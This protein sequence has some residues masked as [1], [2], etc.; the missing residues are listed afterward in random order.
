MHVRRSFAASL[1]VAVIASA[2]ASTGDDASTTTRPQNKP[3][4]APATS[5]TLGPLEDLGHG[6][7]KDSIK[8]G[9]VYID[10]STIAD[11]VDFQ[12]GD[13]EKIAQAFVDDVNANGGVLGR[14]LVPVYKKYIPIPGTNVFSTTV[15]TELTDDE[16]VFAVLGV[17]YDATGRAQ[18]CLS[19]DHQTIHIGHEMSEEWLNASK[20]LMLTPDSTKEAKIRVL[21]A[22]LKREATLQNRK[23]AVTLTDQDGVKLVERSVNPALK[24]LGIPLGTAG[25]LAIA[26]TDTAEAQSQLQTYLSTWEAEG[27]DTIV[28]VSEL[29][30]AKQF[31]EVIRAKFPNVQLIAAVSTGVG[32]EAKDEIIAKRSPNPYEGILTVE[33]VTELTRYASPK[34][35]ACIK[36]YEEATKSKVN[37]PD[38]PKIVKG[39]RDES[40][41]AIQDFCGEIAMFVTIAERVGRTL[42]NENWMKTVDSFG[43][44]EIV[45]TDIASLGANKY[46]ADDAQSLVAWD[47]SLNGGK[48]GWKHLTKVEDTFELSK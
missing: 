5:T 42:T 39:D 47:S 46:Y 34:T 22:L 2:C 10:Y 19:K 38:N 30:S 27:V 48:G 26:G 8:I 4:A 1:V 40:Y 29:V 18:L 3:T 14:K 35:Q 44:I 31:T 24:S 37:G 21:F 17:V 13:Q 33:G 25:V 6:V 41:V 45:P 11:F 28:L 16:D 36:I 43:S 7:T 23:K 32:A 12:R 20:G 15:C 9:L